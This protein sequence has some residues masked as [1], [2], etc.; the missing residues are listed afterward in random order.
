M[1]CAAGL[2]AT[3]LVVDVPIVLITSGRSISA[4]VYGTA[5]STGEGTWLDQIH[6]AGPLFFRVVR[7]LPLIACAGLALATRRRF[8][9]RSL[10][11]EIL[12]ALVASCLVLR[13]VFEVN[14]WGYYFMASAVLLLIV[15][16]L[17]RRFRVSYV[18]WLLLVTYATIDGGLATTHSFVTLPIWLWQL[19]LV[20]T[21]LVLAYGPLLHDG[22]GHSKGNDGGPLARATV[23]SESEA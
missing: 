12:V 9:A 14:L 19:I 16:V 13:L 5:Q 20:P 2:I 22:D 10:T 11:P 8:G 4:I 3:L 23:I 1:K 7:L 17:R 18:V 15:D 21:A 6:F